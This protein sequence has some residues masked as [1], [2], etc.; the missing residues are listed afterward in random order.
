MFNFH[1]QV[2]DAIEKKFPKGPKSLSDS[3]PSVIIDEPK[4]EPKHCGPNSNASSGFVSGHSGKGEM[5]KVII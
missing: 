5:T 1:F 4:Y 2:L 3:L